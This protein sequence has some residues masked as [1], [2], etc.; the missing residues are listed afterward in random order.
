[1]YSLE[2]IEFETNNP[3]SELINDIA[4]NLKDDVIILG[5][6]GKMGINLALLLKKAI[7][8]NHLPYKVYG[9]ARFTDE[10]NRDLLEAEGILTI[11]IDFLNDEE[12]HKLP[13]VKNVIFMVGYK[14]G[15]TGNEAYTWAINAYLP[16]R[17][18]A[19][20]SEANIVAFS[21]GCVYPLS[22]VR[23]GAPSEEMPPE[24][25]GEYA[26]SCLGRERIFEHFSKENG[27]KVTIFR[28]NYSIDLK[29][30]VISELG[31]SIL[32]G[33]AIDLSM[34]Q[35]NVIW[36]KDACEM[37]IRSLFVASSPA[38]ILNITGP[39][40]LSVR[41]IAERLSE[42]L[43]KEVCFVGEEQEEALLSNA[44]KSHKLFGY[45]KTS[46]REM[47]DITAY[48]LLNGGKLSNKPT[49]FQEREGK[50]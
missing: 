43:H 24:P 36:Q 17:V 21:T 35:V 7:T 41:W 30:G 18:C 33:E 4:Q 46:I 14:F 39:E 19:Y 1:M 50:Y 23:K 12:L 10:A 34:G 48:W 42:A 2:G 3:S 44:S 40:S 27:T 20:Y 6:S 28:L 5:I 8:A 26:Q 29:Y 38:N 31:Q 49:H 11:K 47:I 13:K 9:A 25:L 16:G 15:A 32:A 45:P 22:S 37:A